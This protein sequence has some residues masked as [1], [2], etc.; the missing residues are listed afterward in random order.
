MKSFRSSGLYSCLIALLGFLAVP[1]NSF[2]Q[3]AGNTIPVVTIV[4]T[5]PLAS[6]AG[7]TGT[8]TL[9]RAGPTNAI[10]NVFCAIGGTASNGLDYA[11]ISNFVTIPAGAT[12]AVVTISPVDDSLVEGDES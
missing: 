6:E 9:F 5:D 4:A 7:D 3:T 10:L 1:P 11:L 8:F 12:S 2:G